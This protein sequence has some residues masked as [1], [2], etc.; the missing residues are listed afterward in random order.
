MAKPRAADRAAVAG[1]KG[2]LGRKKRHTANAI[3]YLESIR[4]GLPDKVT[5]ADLRVAQMMVTALRKY[6][7]VDTGRLRDSVRILGGGRRVAIGYKYVP[8][9]LPVNN[10]YRFIQKA[11]EEVEPKAERAYRTRVLRLAKRP[12]RTS[13]RGGN[14]GGNIGSGASRLTTA[15][16]RAL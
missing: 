3:V 14:I 9:T 4:E 10:K 16:R 13:S 8:Y 5:E 6:I 7:P 1:G 11:V 2:G 12:P 15:V